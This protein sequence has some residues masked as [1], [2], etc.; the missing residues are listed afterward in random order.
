MLD[1]HCFVLLSEAVWKVFCAGLCERVRCML[2]KSERERGK[3]Q[4]VNIEKRGPKKL[5]SECTHTK[6]W[7]SPALGL[8][9]KTPFPHPLSKQA[10]YSSAFFSLSFFF[11]FFFFFFLSLL[12]PQRVTSGPVIIKTNTTSGCI[13]W[14]GCIWREER[15]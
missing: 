7:P 14:A 10:P 9:I 5:F 11:L 1:V 13:D 6:S 8:L 15:E 3:D 4:E 12:F 2:R